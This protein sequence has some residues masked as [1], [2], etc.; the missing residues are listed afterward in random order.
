[1]RFTTVA[2]ML[3]LLTGAAQAQ[4]P[5]T[6]TTAPA[7]SPSVGTPSGETVAPPATAPR[8]RRRTLEERFDAA[9]T[10]HDGHLTAEQARSHMPA[11]ARDFDQI[12]TAH[13]GYVTLDQIR[14]HNRAAAA[15]RRAARAKQ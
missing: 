2:A 10:T 12:D 14:D 1:M 6:G 11:V 3:V 8:A 15:A 9:N 7:G 4:A 5:L 13:V